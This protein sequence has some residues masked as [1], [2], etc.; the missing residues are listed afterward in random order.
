MSVYGGFAA[1]YDI[2]MAE[3]DYDGWTEHVCEIFKRFGASP[4]LLLELG[5][6]T[7]GITSRLQKKGFDMIG[8][9]VSSDMLSVAKQKNSDILYI[10]GDM[11][12]FELYGTVD[13][14]L[15]LLDGV[16]YLTSPARLLSCFRLVK[17]Y[18][19][20]FGLFIFDI[21]TRYKY[22]EVLAQNTFSAIYDEAAYIWDNYYYEKKKLNEY[23]ITFF[24]K[25]NGGMYERFEETHYQRA[26][27]AGLIKK[28]LGEAGFETAGVFH[29]L[30]F[31]KPEK[32]SQR[33]FFVARKTAM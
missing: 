8:L 7:G 5:C 14:A 31:R 18:L 30:S 28:L 27:S 9:D 4:N 11:A 13:A 22:A 32:E 23:R 29:G 25:K 20:P 16:N 2:F 26:Y 6:G 33:I 21:N 24:A 10:N 15:C 19:N 3:H 12:S 17:N 1:L